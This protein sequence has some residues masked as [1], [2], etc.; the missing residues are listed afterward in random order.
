MRTAIQRL[1]LFQAAVLAL[2]CGGTAMAAEPVIVD[3]AYVVDAVKR[4]AIVWDA[5]AAGAYRQGHI[6]GAVNIDDIGHVLRDEN[7]EDYLEVGHIEK[8]LGNA[9]IDP[10]REVIVYGAKA[11]PYVY[12]GLVTLQYFNGAN[13]R[14][15]HGG[16]DDW[17]DAGQPVSTEIGRLAPVQL[18]LKARPELLIETAEMVK[19]LKDPQIQI[20]DVRTTKEYRGEDIRAIRGGHIP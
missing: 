5:R 18:K 9:G 8:L 12:F 4:G 11:S 1:F 6:P 15:Y 13:A 10:A 19:R 3:T 14:V 17:K 20:L 7:T 2:I 16:I